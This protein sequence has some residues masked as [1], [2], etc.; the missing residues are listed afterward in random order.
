M[1]VF[2]ILV[3]ISTVLSIFGSTLVML[4][5]YYPLKNRL[6]RGRILL[7]WL[8]FCDFF[9]SLIYFIQSFTSSTS[10]NLD[11]KIAS[12]LDIFFPVASFLWTDVIGKYLYI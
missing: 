7:F 3:R 8:S 6:K 9:T 12:L 10:D 11:C 2:N 4:T 5:S 1:T